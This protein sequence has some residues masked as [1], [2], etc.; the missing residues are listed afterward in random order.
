MKNED[1]DLKQIRL[2][3][4]C[5]LKYGVKCAFGKILSPVN[6]HDHGFIISGM[7]IQLMTATGTTKKIPVIFENVYQIFS[8]IIHESIRL[9]EYSSVVLSSGISRPFSLSSEI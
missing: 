9:I 7:E 8:R 3:Q 1:P 5:L 2:A 4:T 6:R